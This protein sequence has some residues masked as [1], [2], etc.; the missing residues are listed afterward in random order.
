MTRGV[1]GGEVANLYEFIRKSYPNEILIEEKETY[2]N[3]EIKRLIKR[4][5]REE[6]WRI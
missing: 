4:E 1:H 5:L 3:I 6:K 2:N